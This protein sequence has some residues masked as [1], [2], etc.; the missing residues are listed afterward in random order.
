M[1]QFTRFDLEAEL[2]VPAGTNEDK[3]LRLMEKAEHYCLVTNSLKGET[4]FA[5]TVRVTG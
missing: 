2:A 4:H 3:A 5:A 1:T